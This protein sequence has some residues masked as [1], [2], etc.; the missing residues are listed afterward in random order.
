MEHHFLL[1]PVGATL[2]AH[3]VD[4]VDIAFQGEVSPASLAPFGFDQTEHDSPSVTEHWCQQQV[5]K[6]D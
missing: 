6:A 2:D 3:G 5:P 4:T 1:A